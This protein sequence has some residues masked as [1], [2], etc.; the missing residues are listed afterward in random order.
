MIYQKV[1]ENYNDIEKIY[2]LKVSQEEKTKFL[3][4][5]KTKYYVG[6]MFADPTVANWGIDLNE[7]D[8]DIVYIK[9]KKN[10]ELCFIIN[11][12]TLICKDI[13]KIEDNIFYLKNAELV[14][15]GCN[16]V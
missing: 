4:K 7:L 11:D 15:E 12:D 10:E 9:R 3:T 5:I 2:S 13:K 6:A 16:T 1:L 8:Q 14:T